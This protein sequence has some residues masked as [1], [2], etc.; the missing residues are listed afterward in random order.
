MNLPTRMLDRAL[1]QGLYFRI[2][3]IA[4]F[5]IAISACSDPGATSA[6][7]AETHRQSDGTDRNQ[8]EHTVQL[9]IWGE[10]SA[11]SDAY[12]T[13]KINKAFKNEKLLIDTTIRV[14]TRSGV[15]TLTG[16]ADSLAVSEK[17]S[18]I[19]RHIAGVKKVENLLII[20]T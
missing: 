1:K 2:Q 4:V 18:D 9:E 17:A 14:E 13:K 8:S 5:C 3:M 12:I 11:L 19:C 20:S 10:Q 7:I 6:Q 16:Y 15:V